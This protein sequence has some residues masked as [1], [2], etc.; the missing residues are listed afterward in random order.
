MLVNG[1]CKNPD[2]DPIV[3][4]DSE[5]MDT[6]DKI[7]KAHKA[8]SNSTDR[9]DII[10]MWCLTAMSK[11]SIRIGSRNAVNPDNSESTIMGRIKKN[12]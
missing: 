2:G 8:S 11:L 7:L 5:I 1:S 12:L 9:D 4:E 3:V 10:V 6:Y